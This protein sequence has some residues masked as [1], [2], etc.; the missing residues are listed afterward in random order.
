MF[1]KP[2]FKAPF[3]SE[4]VKASQT[5]MKSESQHFYHTFSSL[6]ARYTFSKSVLVIFS[7][8]GLFVKTLNADDKCSLRNS[9]NLSEPIQMQLSKILKTFS[10][11]FAQLVQSTSTFKHFEKKLALATYVFSKLLTVK[12]TFRNIQIAPC[13]STLLRSTCWMVQ[14][15][16]KST[17]VKFL[18]HSEQTWLGKPP[19][20]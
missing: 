4:H 14:N 16:K 10:Q 19:S 20:C 2:H 12:G 1:G 9:E 6:L 8:F 13:H 5:L 3:D 11:H 18:C 17:F 7:H 15:K